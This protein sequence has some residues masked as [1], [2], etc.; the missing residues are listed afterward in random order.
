[1]LTHLVLPMSI[2]SAVGVVA[3][4]YM[5]A[6]APSDALRILLG[7]ILAASAVKLMWKRAD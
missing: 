1:M 5:I 6:R 4:G 7:V 3:G 2:G